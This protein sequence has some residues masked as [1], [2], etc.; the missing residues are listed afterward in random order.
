V[1]DIQ[2]GINK[3]GGVTLGFSFIQAGDRLPKAI[4]WRLCSKAGTRLPESLPD[5]GLKTSNLHIRSLNGC[6]G[7][8]LG[9]HLRLR[10]DLSPSKQG[11]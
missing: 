10:G 5:R 11:A 9:Q 4:A 2:Q 1:G 3:A 8:M 6:S 7:G